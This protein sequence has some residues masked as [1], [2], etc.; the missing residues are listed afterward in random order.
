MLGLC[1]S[2]K[3]AIP[4]RAECAALGLTWVRTNVD[5]SLSLVS[6]ILAKLPTNVSLMISLNNQCAQVKGDWSGLEEAC[7]SLVVINDAYHPSRIKIVG[8]GNELD[9]WHL[10]PP[11]GEP[12][13]KLTPAFA[14][15]LVKR[16]APILRPAG[17]KVAMSSVASGS[18]P[19][20]LEEMAALCRGAA[21]HCDL[22]VYMK[23]INRIPEDPGWQ[24]ADAALRQ[25]ANLSGLP[26]I[27]S[28]AGIKV[29]DC[30]GE[31]WQGKWAAG[32][33]DLPAE[34]I[35]Y[36]CWH[37]RMASPGETGEAAF[38]ARDLDGRAKP[39]WT[40][41]QTLFGGPLAK[42]PTPPVV[43]PVPPQ[44]PY[45]VGEDIRAAMQKRGDFA[46]GPENYLASGVSVAPG[47]R[48]QFWWTPA[49]R[50]VR[51]VPWENP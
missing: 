7:R 51:V 26:V 46:I 48:F 22:H 8:I 9:L 28:E 37:D 40:A 27:A 1:V 17:I 3:D 47:N 38:G 30:G 29:R 12:D 41:L 34:L 19:A 49:S 24:T 6:D 4:D 14:A 25:A 32:L 11:T 42:P 45:W 21:D 15:S 13:P 5:G 35:F 44:D 33:A 31:L 2:A 23:S 39:V 50:T 36:W 43:P 10:Q 16:A 18:W 20:Y